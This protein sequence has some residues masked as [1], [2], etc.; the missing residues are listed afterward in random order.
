MQ[1]LDAKEGEMVIGFRSFPE[2]FS[3]VI[4][5]GSQSDPVIIDKGRFALPVGGSWAEKLAWVRR[6]VEEILNP[7]AILR[8]CVKTI[9][10]NARTKSAPRLQ[11]EAIIIESIFTYKGLVCDRRVK[12]QIKRSIP[13]FEAPARYLD[14]V[15]GSHG[16]LAEVNCPAFQEATIAALS[17][18]PTN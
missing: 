15:V 5:D 2:G 17:V 12:A 14:R 11:I 8:A 9:E 16:N 7:R 3:Y 6:Q 4:L 1:I 13:G 18:L 10:P